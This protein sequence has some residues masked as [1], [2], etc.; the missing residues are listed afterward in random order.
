[1]LRCG[2][3][4]AIE[5]ITVVA[6]LYMYIK[7]KCLPEMRKQHPIRKDQ[8]YCVQMHLQYALWFTERQNQITQLKCG[9][10]IEQKKYTEALLQF[11]IYPKPFLH[12]L[13]EVKIIRR[14]PML[15]MRSIL[16]CNMVTLVLRLGLGPDAWVKNPSVDWYS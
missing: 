16:L 6:S 13:K 15:N 7:F 9:G 8:I 1:M 5:V 3:V 10:I 4:Q 11:A 12:T 14:L 2:H